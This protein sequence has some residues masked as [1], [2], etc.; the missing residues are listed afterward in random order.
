MQLSYH[1]MYAP[2]MFHTEPSRLFSRNVCIIIGNKNILSHSV[3]D[4]FTVESQNYVVIGQFQ[5]I[6]FL[7]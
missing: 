2:H 7:I 1:K 6:L 5:K 3:F 4:S